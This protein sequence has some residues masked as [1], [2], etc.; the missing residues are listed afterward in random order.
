MPLAWDDALD[1]VLG[2]GP[3]LRWTCLKVEATAIAK[4]ISIEENPKSCVTNSHK[5]ALFA[6]S[7]AMTSTVSLQPQIGEAKERLN[8]LESDKTRS[9]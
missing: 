4:D 6:A 5:I 1:I 8:L 3:M 2:V 7:F 9:S